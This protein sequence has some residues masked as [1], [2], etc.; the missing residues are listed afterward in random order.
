[1][2]ISRIKTTLYQIHLSRVSVIHIEQL[3]T[4]ASTTD[5]IA[6]QSTVHTHPVTPTL[7]LK[8]QLELGS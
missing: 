4:P 2:T 1:M 6:P 7:T 3:A 5:L 8:H